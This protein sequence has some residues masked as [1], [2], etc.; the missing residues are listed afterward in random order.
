MKCGQLP[1]KNTRA[2]DSTLFG[3][4]VGSTTQQEQEDARLWKLRWLGL[5]SRQMAKSTPQPSILFRLQKCSLLLPQQC[6][7]MLHRPCSSA[8]DHTLQLLHGLPRTSSLT[9][10]L[11]AGD[12][13]WR[14]AL[15]PKSLCSGSCP[16]RPASAACTSMCAAPPARMRAAG[17]ADPRIWIRSLPRASLSA[18]ETEAWTLAGMPQ[19]SI[20][21]GHPKEYLLPEL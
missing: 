18:T 21:T 9:R 11:A 7:H 13:G 14:R 4:P 3:M 2:F 1:L 10:R 17:S 8:P 20:T 6:L 16:A 15:S 12:F 19:T 5:C